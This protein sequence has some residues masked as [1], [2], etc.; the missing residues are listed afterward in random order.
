MAWYNMVRKPFE[1][2][3]EGGCM[4]FQDLKL[5]FVGTSHSQASL[6]DLN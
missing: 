3:V 2:S 1:H 6:E 5:A 4:A